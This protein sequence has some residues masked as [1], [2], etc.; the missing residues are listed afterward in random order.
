MLLEQPHLGL[1]FIGLYDDKLVCDAFHDTDEFDSTLANHH[2]TKCVVVV[3]SCGDTHHCT[4]HTWLPLHLACEYKFAAT[5]N[6]V[7]D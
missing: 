7:A 3:G 4:G 2:L 5:V 6:R 1:K